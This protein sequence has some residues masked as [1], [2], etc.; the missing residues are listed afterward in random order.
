MNGPENRQPWLQPIRFWEAAE[1]YLVATMSRLSM[2]RGA[3]R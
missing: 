2:L 1:P 3:V